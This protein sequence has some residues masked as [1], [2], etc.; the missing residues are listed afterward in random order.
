MA[1]LS[2]TPV[3]DDPDRSLAERLR[4]AYDNGA[5]ARDRADKQ[6]FRLVERDTFLARLRDAGTPTQPGT[7]TQPEAPLDRSVRLL[8]I[9]AGT[10]QD[11]AFF[12]GHGFEVLATDL[13]P[14]MVARCRA[15][16]IDA[17]VLDI[18]REDLPGPFDAA[19]SVNCLLHVPTADLPAVLRRVRAALR[20]GGLFFLGLW[21][22]LAEEGIAADDQHDPP[23]FFS[24]RTDEEIQRF[25]ADA[26]EIVDFHAV[27]VGELR[28]QALTLRRAV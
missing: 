10:G 25:A 28:F 20:P 21:G 1:R 7:S 13:S 4:S 26:F 8:E 3:T 14:A 6:P 24:F 15:K 11:S 12:R 19:Y 5:A 2:L 18:R 16:G 27:P 23:R 17:R 9:G 22:G